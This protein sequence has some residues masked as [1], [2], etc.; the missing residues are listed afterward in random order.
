[1]HWK[2]TTWICV[3]LKV[4]VGFLRVGNFRLSVFSYMSLNVCWF[5][6]V[7]FRLG[8]PP[9]SRD[10]SV[11]YI[12]LQVKPVWKLK[13]ILFN[14]ECYG[15]FFS[16]ITPLSFYL[17]IEREITSVLNIKSWNQLFV[18]LFFWCSSS[19]LATIFIQYMYYYGSQ[20]KRQLFFYLLFFINS[21]I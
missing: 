9:L 5:S 1:L 7:S 2:E 3:K 4:K 10:M 19:L 14:I 11:T 6:E 15:E 17:S 12:K 21:C 18:L 16:G 8:T 20:S 13:K